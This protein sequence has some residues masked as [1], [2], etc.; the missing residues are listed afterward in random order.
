MNQDE[1]IQDEGDSEESQNN[2]D[3]EMKFTEQ[4]H[5]T[6]DPDNTTVQDQIV[7]NDGKI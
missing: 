3:Y 2:D 5:S 1:N 4:Y 6:E 7:G